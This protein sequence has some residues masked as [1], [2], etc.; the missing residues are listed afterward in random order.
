LRN[1]SP[2]LAIAAMLGYGLPRRLRH[3]NPAGGGGKP[4]SDRSPESFLCWQIT[5]PIGISKT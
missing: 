2:D 3:D 4:G 5:I 1:P